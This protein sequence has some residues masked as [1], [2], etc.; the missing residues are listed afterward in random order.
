MTAAAALRAAERAG[1]TVRLVGADLVLSAASPPAPAIVEALRCKKAGVVALLASGISRPAGPTMIPMS[2]P[3]FEVLVD[4]LTR[5][6]AIPRPHQ[7][8]IDP[9]KAA[10]YWRGRA[11]ADLRQLDGDPAA[12]LA[13]VELEESRAP[14]YD[15]LVIIDFV[16]GDDPP[17]LGLEPLRVPGDPNAGLRRAAL[18]RP[19]SWSD[20][21]A[22]P[23]RDCYC[24]CCGLGRWWIERV[25]PRG[26]RCFTC[27]PPGRVQPGEVTEVR[28]L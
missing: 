1:V 4:R 3:P 19:P 28:T 12:Q 25:D 13:L 27:H 17:V 22:R 5:A 15:G 9:V 18:R 8:P 7:H 10:L 2:V 14:P 21:T 26:W 16:E 24:S 20:R 6:Y 11:I 23:S